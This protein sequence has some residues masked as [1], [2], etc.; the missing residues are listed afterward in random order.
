MISKSW[1][2]WALYLAPILLKDC[3]KK[4]EYYNHFVD[5]VKLLHICLK[6]KIAMVEID[7]LREGFAKWVEDYKQY[8]M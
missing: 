1:S 8:V 2:F 3:F 4:E 5:L 7:Q 6:F